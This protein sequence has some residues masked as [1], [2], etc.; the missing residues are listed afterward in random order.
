M[1]VVARAGLLL[2]PEGV[3]IH[4]DLARIIDVSQVATLTLSLLTNVLAT[5]IIAAKAWYVRAHGAF[6]K[7]LLTMCLD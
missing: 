7:D 3:L 4:R 5:S 1:T 6:W 2:T